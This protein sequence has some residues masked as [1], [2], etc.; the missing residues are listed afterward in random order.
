METLQKIFPLSIKYSDTSANLVVGIIIYIA[1]G[2]VAGGILAL[3]GVLAS[4]IPVVGSVIA[5]LLTLVGS[6]VEFYVFAGIVVLALVFTK[7]IK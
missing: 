1:A 7:V 4:I 6:L 2:L 3:A 5:V